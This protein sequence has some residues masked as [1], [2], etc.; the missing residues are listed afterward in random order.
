MM[1]F[2]F[3]A[4]KAAAYIAERL[5]WDERT[6]VQAL[7]GTLYLADKSHFLDWG[8]PIFGG[9]YV[10]ER[11]G[12]VHTQI[13]AMLMGDPVHLIEAKL[14]AYPWRLD[15]RT[16]VPVADAPVP[17]HV[18]LMALSDLGALRDARRAAD[19]VL[20][21]NPGRNMALHDE[22]WQR[23]Q[24]GRILFEDIAEQAGIEISEA[25][26]SWDLLI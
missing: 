3:N 20:S 11:M 6:D 4:E 9:H 23:A 19:E 16:I 5:R 24:D 14:P 17:D 13:R 21:A 25:E 8:R 26:D 18:M 2:R 22:A 1:K 12:P 7:F 10:A 15:G